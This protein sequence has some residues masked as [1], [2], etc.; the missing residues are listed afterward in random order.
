MLKYHF[1]QKGPAMHKTATISALT[2]LLA[3]TVLS[4][5]VITVDN[6]VNSPG[7]YTDLQVAIGAASDGDTIYVSGS[8]TSYGS[9][10]LVKRLTL[11][12]AG[13]KPDKQL[14]LISIIGTITF[15]QDLLQGTSS[16]GSKIIGFEMGRFSSVNPGGFDDIEIRRNII[17]SGTPVQISGSTSGWIIENNILRVQVAV[18]GA[19][20]LIIN[21][22]ILQD[23]IVNSN[24]PTVVITNN[25]FLRDGN[26]FAT[27]TNAVISNNI[28]Y[29]AAPQGCSQSFF[30]N[31]LTYLTSNDA[32]PYGDNVG[33]GNLVGVDPQ[34]VTFPPA[35]DLFS[36]DYDFH[37]QAA[38]P[39]IGAGTDGTDIGAYG[40][41]VPIQIGGEPPLPQVIRMIIDNVLPLDG[42]M[43][44]EATAIKQN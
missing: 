6:K 1:D 26:A 21:N 25:L 28:F 43:H 44:I 38:S 32:L 31:N 16:S 30:N 23:L 34:F 19:T 2:F 5:A 33:S 42:T 18:G 37:L 22:N 17:T 11:F 7:Q 40:G 36:F 15:A 29:R 14:P 35:G 9:I 41:A 39:A 13:Y 24:Q 3:T 10:T 8:E 20:S 12:G 27:M 4:G